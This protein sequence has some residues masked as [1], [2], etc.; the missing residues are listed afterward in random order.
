VLDGRITPPRRAP[1][2]RAHARRDLVE[3]E[4]L[5]DVIVRAGVQ[6]GHTVPDVIARGQHDDR[7]G[8]A[9]PPQLAQHVEAVAPRQAEIEQH[10]VERRR[11]QRRGRGLA[12]AHPIHGKAGRA[13]RRLQPLCNHG[14]V[15]D[16]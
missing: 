4:G 1:Q 13:Q 8:V 7:G 3:I 2:H 6:P 5:D 14:V 10:Q 15:L 9:A 16:Q 11:A 12:V